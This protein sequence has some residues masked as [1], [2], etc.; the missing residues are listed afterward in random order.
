MVGPAGIEPA[1]LGLEMNFS[2]IDRT[3][4]TASVLIFQ[5]IMFRE[6]PLKFL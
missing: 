2:R 3:G 4:V 6:H 5:H 1:T